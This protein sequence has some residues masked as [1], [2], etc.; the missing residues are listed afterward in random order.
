LASPGVPEIVAGAVKLS[1]VGSVVAVIVGVVPSGS[2]APS[3]YRYVTPSVA[4]VGGEFVA[5][6]GSLTGV[7]AIV[8]VVAP[9]TVALSLAR[10]VKVVLPLKLAG[11]V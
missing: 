1:Q 4:V 8:T 10:Y 6:G 9:L 3:V 7:T 5:N 11:G 2:D